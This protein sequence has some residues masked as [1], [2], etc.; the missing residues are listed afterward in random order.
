MGGNGE[1]R[2]L[3]VAIPIFE[4]M[5]MLDA[6]GPYDMLNTVPH[7]D[8]VFV[9]HKRGLVSDLGSFTMEAKASFDEVITSVSVS[10]RP[11]IAMKSGSLL[12]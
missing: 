10:H 11:Q 6:V 9:G 7:V 4:N 5:T 2:R 12:P 8:V 3:Q 1:S